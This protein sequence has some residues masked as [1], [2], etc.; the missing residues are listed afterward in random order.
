MSNDEKIVI[1]DWGGV[2]ESHFQGENNYYSAKV[3]IIN[4]LNEQT[5]KIDATT[6]CKKWIECDYDQNG[7]CISEVN[8]REDIQKWFERIKLKFDLK[9]DYNEFYAVY[10]EE[11]DKIKYYKE[12]VD[13]AHSLKN[14]CKI[15]I[16][17]NLADIDR[18]RIDKHYDL[19]KFDYVWLSFDL[20]CKKPNQKIYDI[21]VNDCKLN[22]NNILFIDDKEDNLEIPKRMGWQILQATGHDLDKIKEK[23]YEFLNKN[24]S[25]GN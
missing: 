25:T 3:D 20:K 9:C 12:V 17:S 14:K 7:K 4:R 23:V 2:V 22:P 6:I 16:L 10:K 24:R 11:S 21:V 8:S 13:F 1:F 18:E 5:K 15:G 19:S